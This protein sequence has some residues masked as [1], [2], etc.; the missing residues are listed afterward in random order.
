MKLTRLVM[1]LCL[2]SWVAF[3][4]HASAHAPCANCRCN[5]PP[6]K[7]PSL[8]TSICN[9]HGTITTCGDY[10]V[11]EDICGLRFE[12]TQSTA[13]PVMCA[14]SANWTQDSPWIGFIGAEKLRADTDHR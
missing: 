14:S 12:T 13:L 5:F 7:P 10:G 3:S 6:G 8:C 9:D 1:A 2:L 4:Q 11:C